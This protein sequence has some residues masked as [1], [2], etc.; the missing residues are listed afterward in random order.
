[1]SL[2]SPREEREMM[3]YPLGGEGGRLLVWGMTNFC[4]GR[5][6]GQRGEGKCIV[7]VSFKCDQC[8]GFQGRTRETKN[9]QEVEPRAQRLRWLAWVSAQKPPLENARRLGSQLAAAWV[10]M[11]RSAKLQAPHKCRVRYLGGGWAQPGNPGA[12]HTWA[13]GA[14]E[15]HPPSPLPRCPLRPLSRLLSSLGDPYGKFLVSRG[16]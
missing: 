7:L 6:A 5:E 10:E 13:S 4:A 8:F 15:H 16:M 11:G 9:N 1:M 3:S 12:Q 14:L 2:K